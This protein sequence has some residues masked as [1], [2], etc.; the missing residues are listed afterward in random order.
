[1]SS[2][3][4]VRAWMNSPTP[5]RILDHHAPAD[6]VVTLDA[7]PIT[8]PGALTGLRRMPIAEAREVAALAARTMRHPRIVH[9][10]TFA[11]VV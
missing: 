9:V 10:D 2:A 4:T 11:V 1:M 3:A 7:R 5:T 8:G 6:Y